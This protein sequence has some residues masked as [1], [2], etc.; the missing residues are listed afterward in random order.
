MGEQVFL[1]I[2]HVGDVVGGEF[3]AVT[4]GDG[5]GGASLDAVAAEDAAGVVNVVNLGVAF[6]GA[7]AGFGGVVGGLDVDALHRAGGGTEEAGDALFQ[8]VFVAVQDVDAA[9]AVF[10]AH[11][12]VG[13]VF[14]DGGA[15]ERAQGDGETLCEGEDGFGGFF[16]YGWHRIARSSLREAPV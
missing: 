13:V 9:V 10:E 5:V 7:D 12:L 1:A 2:D 8:S 11:R 15:E 4:V 3:E 14:G 6:A 16:E